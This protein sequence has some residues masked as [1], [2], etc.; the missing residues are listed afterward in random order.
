[1]AASAPNAELRFCLNGTSL[2]D[3]NSDTFDIKFLDRAHW[4]RS[5]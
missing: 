1:M 5:M 3:V 4:R 2:G